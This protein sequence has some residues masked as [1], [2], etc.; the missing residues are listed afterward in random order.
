M[1]LGGIHIILFLFL[2]ENVCCGYS[3][4]VP[5]RGTSN[6]YPQL[7][8]SWRNKKK[9]INTVEKLPCLERAK[10]LGNKKEKK[11]KKQRKKNNIWSCSSLLN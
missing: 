5:H 10:F 3:L 4:E 8:F 7:M 11:K 6:E 1:A 2:Y 9:S